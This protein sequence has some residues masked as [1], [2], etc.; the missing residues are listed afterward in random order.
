MLK[1]LTFRQIKLRIFDTITIFCC[2]CFLMSRISILPAQ[3]CHSQVYLPG[4]IHKLRNE[5]FKMIQGLV[6][7]FMT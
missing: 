7:Y 3:M 5:R 2:Y 1:L 4:A 6:S